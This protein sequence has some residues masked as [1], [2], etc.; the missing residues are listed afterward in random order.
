MNWRIAELASSYAAGSEQ[1]PHYRDDHDFTDTR[2]PQQRA[3]AEQRSAAIWAQAEADDNA[4]RRKEEA[5]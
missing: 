4:R 5:A 3:D 1:D 2:T